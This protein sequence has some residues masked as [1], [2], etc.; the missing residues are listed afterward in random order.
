MVGGQL[1]LHLHNWRMMHFVLY[2]S[3]S[4]IIRYSNIVVLFFHVDEL[5]L[6]YTRVADVSLASKRRHRIFCVCGLSTC[7]ITS[8]R[9]SSAPPLQLSQV[10]GAH[11]VNMHVVI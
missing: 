8:E 10:K 4:V 9:S 7:T 6:F 11:F 1:V 5:V 3:Q 2:L